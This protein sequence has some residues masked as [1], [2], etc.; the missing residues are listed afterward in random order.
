MNDVLAGIRVADFSRVWAGPYCS[1]MLAELGAEVIKVE[2]PGRGDETRVWPPFYKEKS[3][4]FMSFNRSKKSVTLNLK[5][6]R[7]QSLA[8]DLIGK[9]DILLENYTPG[10]TERLGIDYPAASRAN[11]DLVYCSISSFGQTGPL[12]KQRGYDPVLQAMSGI[13]SLTGEP[14]RPPVRVGV[15]IADLSGALFAAFAIVSALLY[16]ERGDGPRGQ[17]I[18]ISMLDSQISLLAVKAFEFLHEGKLPQRW[19]SGDPQRVPSAAYLTKDGSYIMI[20]ASDAHWPG[21]C[22]VVGRE[23]LIDDERFNTT[24]KRVENRKE[25]EPILVE[26]LLKRPGEE[27]LAGLENAGVPCGPVHTLDQVFHHPQTLAREI[28]KEIAHPEIET[29]RA[30]DW[31]YKLSKTPSRIRSASPALGEHTEEILTGLLGRSAEEVSRLRGGG[32]L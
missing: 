14:D 31:P 24:R 26:S 21:F 27:W 11:P 4:Y 5:D 13:M 10:V 23:D 12:G 7:G 8:L 22:R 6:P 15:A 2:E 1:M 17:H 20:I 16:R 3:G 9:C 25:L 18:D 32:V 28:V 29:L 30:I 19:G